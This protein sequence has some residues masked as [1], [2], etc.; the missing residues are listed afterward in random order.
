MLDSRQLRYF[1]AVAEELHFGRAAQR[2]H[3]AQPPLSQQIRKLEEQLGVRLFVRDNRNVSLTPEGEFLLLQGRRII[4]D[5]R[6]AEESILSMARGEA[7]NIRMGFVGPAMDTDLATRILEF[8]QQRP[9][10]HLHLEEANTMNQLDALARGDLDVGHV[11]LYEHDTKG[12]AVRRIVQEPYVLALPPGHRLARKRRVFLAELD[13]EGLVSYP[14]EIQPALHDAISS[15]L[16]L[17]GARVTIVQEAKRKET[18]LAL[19]AVASG[20]AIVPA[21]ARRSGRKDVLFREIKDN[22]LPDVELFQI[23]NPDRV[24]TALEHFLNFCRER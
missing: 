9:A 10:I 2:L 23:W 13:G 21:S 24:S 7:G 5:L 19:V 14:R 11:R 16:Q 8:R 22:T 1:L 17:A 6:R 15:A 18:V 12:F 3:M 20:V 4:Q